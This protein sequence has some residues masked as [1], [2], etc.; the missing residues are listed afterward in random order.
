[1]PVYIFVCVFDKSKLPHSRMVFVGAVEHQKRIRLAKHV[2]LVEL[3][4][5]EL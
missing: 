1:V 5:R 3:L 2:L 4:T